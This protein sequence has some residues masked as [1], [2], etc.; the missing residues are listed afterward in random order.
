MPSGLKFKNSVCHCK[1]KTQ[2]I[3]CRF[4]SSHIFTV[5]NAYCVIVVVAP[6]NFAFIP[7]PL[8][9]CTFSVHNT[10]TFRPTVTQS[11]ALFKDSLNF[12]GT[13]QFCCEGARLNNDSSF[14]AR[15]AFPNF[16]EQLNDL[17]YSVCI[18]FSSLE[19]QVLQ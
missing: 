15:F 19:N 17:L 6:L 7:A 4:P 12:T 5:K 11:L 13:F 3:N 8:E 2:F 10:I 9:R 16:S 18:C 14:F 1:C